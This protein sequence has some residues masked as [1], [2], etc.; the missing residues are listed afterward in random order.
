[1]SKE[2][3]DAGNKARHHGNALEILAPHGIPCVAGRPDHP[4]PLND[5]ITGITKS[6]NACLE[7]YPEANLSK[8]RKIAISTFLILCNSTLVCTLIH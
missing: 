4:K 5:T 1:M 8:G 7:G 6:R 2:M 3:Q